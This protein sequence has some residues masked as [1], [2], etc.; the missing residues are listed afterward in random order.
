[1]CNSPRVF[2]FL[3][4]LALVVSTATA[5]T[6][7][8]PRANPQM[9]VNAAVECVTAPA[10]ATTCTASYHCA[11]TA[12]WAYGIAPADFDKT[13][14][15]IPIGVLRWTPTS[16]SAR[17][18]CA[19]HVEGNANVTAFR[20]HRRRV[21]DADWVELS[22]ESVAVHR[23]SSLVSVPLP[24]D[25]T[26]GLLS[27]LLKLLGVETADA[28]IHR[29]CTRLRE[30]TTRK[31]RC[32]DDSAHLAYAIAYIKRDEY[33]VCLLHALQDLFAAYNR[34]GHTYGD[35]EDFHGS[36]YGLLENGVSPDSNVYDTFAHCEEDLR[37]ALDDLSGT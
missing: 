19:L 11:S 31:Q 15:D 26:V 37:P 34:Q 1:M 16:T 14:P 24:A 18:L 32:L 8:L 36:L 13:L 21:N 29:E 20:N 35:L 4:P 30:G 6:Y 22:R 10:N 3:C 23:A 27:D 2:A 9:P 28:L 12:D 17:D 25:A 5:E 7:Q 33:S